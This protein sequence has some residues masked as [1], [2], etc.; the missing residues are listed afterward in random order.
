MIW[1]WTMNQKLTLLLMTK[2]P[3]QCL[4]QHRHQSVIQTCA[5]TTLLPSAQKQQSRRGFAP[6]KTLNTSA[7]CLASISS[8][9]CKTTEDTTINKLSPIETY[10]H[11]DRCL[12]FTVPYHTPLSKLKVLA[13][14]IEPW[15]LQGLREA[16]QTSASRQTSAQSVQSKP[17]FSSAS[18]NQ[19]APSE[20]GAI[21]VHFQHAEN[22]NDD[23]T[24]DEFEDDLSDRSSVVE[25]EMGASNNNTSTEDNDCSEKQEKPDQRQQKPPQAPR[26][27]PTRRPT[28]ASLANLGQT[29]TALSA[30]NAVS[31]NNEHDSNGMSSKI[32]ELNP[33]LPKAYYSQGDAAITGEGSKVPF[34]MSEEDSLGAM[35]ERFRRR[36]TQEERECFLAL[37]TEEQQEL[38]Q[39]YFSA[40]TE[41]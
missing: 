9:V 1:D 2:L 22:N 19:S 14:V 6:K 11:G 15:M 35:R 23:P 36:L 16:S 4:E 39:K 41:P 20:Y 28:L 31:L 8:H 3:L 40:T 29:L 33:L 17:L 27:G 32:L 13:R 24:G 10:H 21:R 30:M 38:A 18:E 37:R 7:P 26:T 34:A 12:R 5:T 25:N